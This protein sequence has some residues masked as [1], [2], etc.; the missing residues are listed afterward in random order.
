MRWRARHLVG[1]WTSRSAE[2]AFKLLVVGLACADCAG[3]RSSVLAVALQP[4]AETEIRLPSS[5]NR[6]RGLRGRCS[7]DALHVAPPRRQAEILRRPCSMC[8]ACRTA[9]G[10]CAWW[11][12]SRTRV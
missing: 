10:G 2:D 1:H 11:R 6:E 8:L 7:A 4:A 5:A 9:A 3:G 12:P